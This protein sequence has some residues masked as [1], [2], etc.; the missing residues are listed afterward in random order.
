MITH[1]IR[2]TVSGSVGP[3]SYTY[4]YDHDIQRWLNQMGSMIARFNDKSLNEG[5]TEEQLD[6]L[7]D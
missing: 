2:G 5:L 7:P 4:T 3:F 6:W 1:V